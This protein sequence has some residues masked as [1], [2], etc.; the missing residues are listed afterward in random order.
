[1]TNI[2]VRTPEGQTR[3]ILVRRGAALTIGSDSTCDIRL[4]DDTVRARHGLLSRME[5]GHFELY[6][7]TGRPADD[8]SVTARVLL[9]PG[10]PV[11]IG[12]HVL[13]IE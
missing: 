4:A 11:R 2:I 1:M 7:I 5:D 8:A 10:D 3:R 13:V 12:Q 6:P 9:R